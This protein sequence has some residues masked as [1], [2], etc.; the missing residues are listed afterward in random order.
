MACSYT[1][2][3][4]IAAPPSRSLNCQPKAL[5]L[6]RSS[7]RTHAASR[8]TALE[9]G[10]AAG[11]LLAS[12]QLALAEEQAFET[13]EGLA[14][15]PTSYG[16]YGGNANEDPKYSFDYPSGWKVGAV[17]KVQK[18]T[19][20]IDC[21]ISNPRNKEMRAFVITLGRAGED[22]KSFRLTDVDSTF[23]GFAGADYDLQDALVSSTDSKKAE[24]EVDGRKFFD[25]DISSPSVRY[26]STVTV[27]DGKVF[28]LFIKSPA[29]AFDR[30]EDKFRAMVASF[31]TL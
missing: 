27:K 10:L 16:G 25:Y 13:Y 1:T 6:R 28:A 3:P 31:K 21:I 20:G 29:K 4:I 23:A 7:V 5:P 22:D 24:R 26:L 8:R 19:Q 11:A 2:K 30:M 14:T 9:L 12:P 15:P 18:G 17:N